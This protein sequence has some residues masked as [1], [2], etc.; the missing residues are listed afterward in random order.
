VACDK[1]QRNVI[2]IAR[3][4]FRKT[5]PERNLNLYRYLKQITRLQMICE[6]KDFDSKV[7]MFQ[8]NNS[9]LALSQ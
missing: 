6:I 1:I 2:Q 4:T 5:I 7:L 9:N 3:K 8:T